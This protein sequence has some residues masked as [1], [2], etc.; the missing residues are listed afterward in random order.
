MEIKTETKI[1]TYIECDG[2]K[3]YSDKRGYW[4]SSNNGGKS[5][6]KRLHVY[7]WEKHNGPVPSGYHIHH[8]DGDTNN[9][10]IENLLMMLQEEHL[11]MHRASASNKAISKRNMQNYAQPKA[12]EWHKSAAGH[13]WHISQY[14]NVKDRFHA[15][16]CTVCAVCGKEVLSRPGT[17]FCSN[18]CKSKHRREMGYDNVAKICQHCGKEYWYSKYFKTKYCSLNCSARSRHE[19]A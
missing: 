2:M 9:N 18:A 10:E 7:V 11:K 14:A 6:P 19:S 1:V 17:K 16:V 13:T 4:I 8:I 12:I 3:F 5:S 15:K